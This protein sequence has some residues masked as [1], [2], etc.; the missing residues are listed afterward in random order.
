MADEF[1]YAT[2]MGILVNA[3]EHNPTVEK[4]V[5]I[6]LRES[7]EG[8]EISVSDNGSGI[9][10]NQKANLFD[11]QRRFG[12]VSLH[13]TKHALEK[14]RGT[15][16]VYDRIPGEPEK[17]AEFLIWLPKANTSS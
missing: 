13:L 5:W 3:V 16:K 14:Y 4:H 6:R 9:K 7:I 2:I 1:I 8:Y 12:G 17:G 11:T 15:I 10:E